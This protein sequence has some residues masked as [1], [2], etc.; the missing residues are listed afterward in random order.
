M[1]QKMSPEEKAREIDA[2]LDAKAPKDAEEK[3]KEGES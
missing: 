3:E 1:V 2:A